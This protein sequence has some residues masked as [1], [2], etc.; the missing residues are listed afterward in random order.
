MKKKKARGNFKNEGIVPHVGDLVEY[1]QLEDGDGIVE[2]IFPRKNQFIRPPI[3]NIDRFIVVM[4]ATKPK[5]NFAIID[6]FL[7]MA[8]M[9]HIEP[10][11][12]INKIDLVKEK[13]LQE[14]VDFAVETL[15]KPVITAPAPPCAASR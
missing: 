4:A 15:V 5:P 13:K 12:C 2:G 8:E 11:L 1:Q 3:A 10:V 9:N 6:K 14:I 7:I